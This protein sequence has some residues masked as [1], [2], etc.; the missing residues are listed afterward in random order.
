[1]SERVADGG[2]LAHGILPGFCPI[3]HEGLV[4]GQEQGQDGLQSHLPTPAVNMLTGY[5]ERGITVIHLP[6]AY[7]FLTTP[8]S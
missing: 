7:S 4:L 3:S 6:V 2:G 5:K 8:W 1:M